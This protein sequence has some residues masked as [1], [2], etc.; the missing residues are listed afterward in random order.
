[1][2]RQPNAGLARARNAGLA[3]ARGRFISFLDGDDLIAPDFYGHA[4]DL[5]EREPRL[6]GVAAWAETFGEGV[7]PGFWNAP[8]PELPLLLVENTVFVPCMVRTAL[9]RELGG[10]DPEQRYNYEDWELSIRLL[11]SGHPIITIPRYLHRY[12]V[13]RDSLFRTMTAAQNQTMRELLLEKHR[14]TLQRFPVEVSMLL[15]GRMMK[16]VHADRPNPVERLRLLPVR[17]AQRTVRRLAARSA[18]R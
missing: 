2:L 6:G 9:L 4:L 5:L 8:Q 15:E 10:Y 12:R 7:A 1:V 13:R 16:V 17:L 3:A 14:A 18:R 11:A